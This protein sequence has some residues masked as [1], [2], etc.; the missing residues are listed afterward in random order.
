MT[1]RRGS[2]RGISLRLSAFVTKGEANEGFRTV[3]R[4]RLGDVRRG[5][6]RS[7]KHVHVANDATE[8]VEHV[9]IQPIEQPIQQSVE[10]VVAVVVIDGVVRSIESQLVVGRSVEFIGRR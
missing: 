6:Q 8:L 9:V 7:P 4:N 5:V 2:A 10:P 3:R 1:T